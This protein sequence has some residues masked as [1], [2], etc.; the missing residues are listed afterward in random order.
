YG[1]GRIGAAVGRLLAA[2]GVRTVG[3]GRTSRYGPEPGTDRTVPPGFDR[4]IG[5]AEDAGVLGEARWVISTLPLTAAT[6]GFFGT[7]RFA[8]VRGA[9]FLNVGR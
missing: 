9:T 3:V 1:T 2:C 5:A 7:E 6:E 4:M 8:A